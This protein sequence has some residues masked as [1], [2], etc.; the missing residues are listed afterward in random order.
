[1]TKQKE[2]GLSEQFQKQ[3]RERQKQ[4][5]RQNE[6]I[7]RFGESRQ[8]SKPPPPWFKRELTKRLKDGLKLGRRSEK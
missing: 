6:L 5:Q 7:K 3:M 2:I 1:M 4:K 8:S